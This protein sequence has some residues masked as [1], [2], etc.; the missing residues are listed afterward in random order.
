[1]G[2]L[3]GDDSVVKPRQRSWG[4]R[5]GQALVLGA[6]VGFVTLGLG[7]RLAM[8]GFAQHTGRPSI[9]T[10]RGTL[11]VALSGS[12]AGALAALLFLA[13]QRWLLPNARPLVRGLAAGALTLLVAAPGIRPPWL[14]TFALFAPAFLAFGVGFVWL[15]SRT[16]STINGVRQISTMARSGIQHPEVVDLITQAA[17]GT[18]RLILAETDAL[19]GHHAI[20]LQQKLQN[21]LTFASGGQLVA[22][23]P[24]A[25]GA[26]VRIRVDLYAEP[27]NLI[28]TL[29]RAFRVLSLKQ[30]VELELS[31][32]QQDVL[33]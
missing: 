22:A 18:F 8:F 11:T 2:Y 6:A 5:I 1:M 33:L 12:M 29:L 24:K 23:H 15:W 7:G 32:H 9:W 28:L 27:D 4:A 26:P 3:Q 10:L 16:R 30:G 13:V 20:A 17:D 21:Y 25:E 31:I 19:A 14:V